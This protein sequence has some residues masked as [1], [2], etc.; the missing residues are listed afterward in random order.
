MRNLGTL[1]GITLIAG[2]VVITAWSVEPTV[3]KT[4][5]VLLDPLSM[6]G[7][8][9][10]LLPEVHYDHGFHFSRRAITISVS[11]TCCGGSRVVGHFIH[12]CCRLLASPN[13][14]AKESEGVST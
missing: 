12:P 10:N 1:F 4:P 6:T 3:G 14:P 8:V 7:T 5:T 11:T 9:T 2:A 13:M